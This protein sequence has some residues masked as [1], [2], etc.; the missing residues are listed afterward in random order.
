MNFDHYY[1][2]PDYDDEGPECPECDEG[3]GEF[4]E[5]EQRVQTY[6]CDCCNHE[7]TITVPE[8]PDPEDL[9]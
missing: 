4:I 5:E 7:W 9:L 8:D 3:Y 2:P 1:D 6:R